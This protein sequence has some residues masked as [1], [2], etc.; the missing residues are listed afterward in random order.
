MLT[1]TSK[2]RLRTTSDVSSTAPGNAT[3]YQVYISVDFRWLIVPIA[4][5]I[6][7]FIFL[8]AVMAESRRCG[9]PAWKSSQTAALLC[10][11][12]AAR[13]QV[14][15]LDTAKRTMGKRADGVRVRLQ[16]EGRDGWQLAKV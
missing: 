9:V 6:F 1:F 12:E 8:L 10:L 3:T 5:V 4:S 13:K 7:A 11:D 2:K 16:R 15:P 14:G